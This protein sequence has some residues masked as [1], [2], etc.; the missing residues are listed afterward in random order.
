MVAGDLATSIV[1]GLCPA[2]DDRLFRD[3]LCEYIRW[4]I[5]ILG[6]SLET[7]CKLK[8]YLEWISDDDGFAIAPARFSK[9]VLSAHSENILGIS[10][11]FGDVNKGSSQS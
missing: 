2:D 1:G 8:I 6:K 3:I 4:R 7:A 10:A 9:F 5:R 11:E